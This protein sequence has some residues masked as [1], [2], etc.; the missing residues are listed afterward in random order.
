MTELIQKDKYTK[1]WE[2]LRNLLNLRTAP[3]A[4]KFYK[5]IEDVPKNIPPLPTPNIWLCQSE[6]A[7]KYNGMKFYVTEDTEGCYL[8]AGYLGLGDWPP[9]W[10]E[11]YWGIRNAT[12]EIYYKIICGAPRI[13]R[14]AIKAYSME[15]LNNVTVEPDMINLTVN[16]GQ[17]TRIAQAWTYMDGERIKAGPNGFSA[18]CATCGEAIATAYVMGDIEVGFPCLGAR[19]A[20]I[21]TDEELYITLPAN[22]LDRLIEGLKLTARGISYP[23]AH[24]NV[25]SVVQEPFSCLASWGAGKSLWDFKKGGG[26]PVPKKF[27]DGEKMELTDKPT[28]SAVYKNPQRKYK[29]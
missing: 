4:V 2:E 24:L 18:E 13:P 27:F 3:V 9:D 1:A 12:P 20:G 5:K 14:G 15:P 25:T 8:A 29:K 26:L 23:F 19:V 11:R 17:S 10:G 16:G 6:N 21:S 7:V 28:E 22:Q